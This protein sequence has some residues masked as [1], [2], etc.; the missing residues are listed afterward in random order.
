MKSEKEI[1][2]DLNEIDSQ[3]ECDLLIHY[4]RKTRGLSFAGC[5]TVLDLAIETFPREYIIIKKNKYED[6]GVGD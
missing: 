4:L 2:K 3:K 1:K 6:I 5:L